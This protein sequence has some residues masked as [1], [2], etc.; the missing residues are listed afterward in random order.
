M[1]H[2]Q[3][4][5]AVWLEIPSFSNWKNALLLTVIENSLHL[6]TYISTVNH[7]PTPLTN[8]EK[9]LT[10]FYFKITKHHKIIQNST[11]TWW[12][13][14]S[15]KEK[16]RSPITS[17]MHSNKTTPEPKQ[18][19]SQLPPKFSSTLKLNCHQPMYEYTATRLRNNKHNQPT[20]FKRTKKSPRKKLR[21]T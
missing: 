19:P 1:K 4:T 5:T 16:T 21:A 10:P 14:K 18:S 12:T 15:K 17:K 6:P 7:I 3:R 2:W 8:Q 13:V 20:N 11:C 9:N